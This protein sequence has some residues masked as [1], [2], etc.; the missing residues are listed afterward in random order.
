M[1]IGADNNLLLVKNNSIR[2]DFLVFKFVWVIE[3]LITKK[4]TQENV[5]IKF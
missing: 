5:T 2:D 1:T 4:W 3:I